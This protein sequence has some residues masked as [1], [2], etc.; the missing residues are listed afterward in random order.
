MINPLL[1][2]IFTRN[3]CWFMGND[4]WIAINVIFFYLLCHIICTINRVEFLMSNFYILG[5]K[6]IWSLSIMLQVG[7]M[8]TSSKVEIYV[9]Q[10]FW[11]SPTSR[12]PWGA[13][14]PNSPFQSSAFAPSEWSWIEA[15]R[16]AHLHPQGGCNLEPWGCR[17]FQPM[18]VPRERHSWDWSYTNHPLAQM[19]INEG[20][21]RRSAGDIQPP[22]RSNSLMC[23][24]VPGLTFIVL[25]QSRFW[26]YFS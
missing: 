24:Q 5:L 21:Q 22:P 10:Q 25:I 13:G 17:S 23:Y 18:P 15:R 19:S 11:W 6:Q 4:I 12:E 8:E 1:H 7:S 9:K 26:L 3:Y 20:G 16:L 2:I 14:S